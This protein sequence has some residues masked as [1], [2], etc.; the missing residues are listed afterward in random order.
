MN[1]G[2]ASDSMDLELS[3]DEEP[4]R[5]CAQ[6]YHY[7]V[8]PVRLVGNDVLEV[9]SGRGGG[10]RFLA[11]HHSPKSMV[12]VDFSREAVAFCQKEHRS[13]HL[14]FRQGDAEKLP[15]TDAKFDAVVN[16]ESSHC[17]G[18]MEAFLHEACR[19]LRPG[20]SL[21]FADI[22]DPEGANKLDSQLRSIP[23][24]EVKDQEDISEGVLIAL[25]KDNTRKQQLISEL[26]PG[27]WQ[28]LFDEFAGMSGGQIQGS[29]E[30]G[31]LH[32]LRYWAVKS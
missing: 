11:E 19:V 31:S 5:Y 23:K 13:A 26:I 21:L 24:W 27:R 28:G 6:L 12:G 15:F 3:D 32:Y 18:N 22:R 17:Y 2:Y 4:D 20:G 29:L 16:V 1:Y 30:D 8:S 10:A 14:T 9:G 25:G 7:V